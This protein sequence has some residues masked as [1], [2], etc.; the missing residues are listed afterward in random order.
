MNALA[1]SLRVSRMLL[2]F[3]F[4]AILI[5]GAETTKAA[6]ADVGYRVVSFDAAMKSQI[7]RSI[8]LQV[9]IPNSYEALVLDP[10]RGVIWAEPGDLVEVKQANAAPRHGNFHGRLTTNVGYDASKKSF[11]CGPGCGE[12]MIVS[13][14]SESVGGG[15]VKSEKHVVNGVPLLLL[16]IDTSRAGAVKTIYM[17]Y[18][19]TLIDTNVVLMSYR[20]APDSQDAGAEV[21]RV[22]RNALIASPPVAMAAPAP[23]PSFETI[24]PRPRAAAISANSPTSSSP[25]LSP[26]MRTGPWVW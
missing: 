16:E 2:A 24:W 11:I 22:F 20:P 4:V 14:M 15:N 10:P 7:A 6:H 19:A 9:A 21:W 12:E 3:P 5:D 1:I 23:E 26:A 18:V 25:Q 8:P 13:R 17:A